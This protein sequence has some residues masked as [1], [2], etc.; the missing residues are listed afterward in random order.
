[1]SAIKKGRSRVEAAHSLGSRLPTEAQDIRG[2]TK[3]RLWHDGI[4]GVP[5]YLAGKVDSHVS[6]RRGCSEGGCTVSAHKVCEGG[7]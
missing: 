2:S 7:G 1:M 4:T 6:L 3:S 5:P